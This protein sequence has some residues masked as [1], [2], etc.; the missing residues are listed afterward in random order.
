MQDSRTEH[1]IK[2]KKLHRAFSQ[3][4]SGLILNIPVFQG[5]PKGEWEG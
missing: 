1:S 2:S 5:S 3:K 4:A